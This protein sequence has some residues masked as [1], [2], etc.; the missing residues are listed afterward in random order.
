MLKRLFLGF[1]LVCLVGLVGCRSAFEV[2]RQSGDPAKILAQANKYFKAGENQ[3][4]QMLYELVI[5]DYRGKPEAEQIFYRYAHTHFNME[6]YLSAAHFFKNFA[7]TF[8][9]SDHRED[10]DF[11]AAYSHY[12]LSPSFRLGQEST[13]KAIE[14][15][16]TFVNTYPTSKRV[17]ECNN[18]IDELRH[19]LEVKAF[20]EAKLYYD[21]R[22]YQSALHAFDNVIIDFPDTDNA[23]EIRYLA[24]KSSQLLAYHSVY[25]KKTDRYIDAKKYA[26]L[27]LRKYPKSKYKKEILNILS[28]VKNEL[29]ELKS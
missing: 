28:Q 21:L 13:I 27:F 29:K 20:R 22:Q 6:Q 3:K 4:A 5:S 17:A 25:G 23:E 9:N 10:A 18:L 2:V 24:V 8:I 14:Q 15:L 12:K 19:K 11:F 16:Q 7:N 1:S 26:E